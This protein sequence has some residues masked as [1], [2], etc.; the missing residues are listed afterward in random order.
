MLSLQFEAEN[1][2]EL[3]KSYHIIAPYLND[4]VNIITI[5]IFL[6]FFNHVVLP[7]LRM[8]LKLRLVI[9]LIFNLIAILIA[10]FLQA[11]VQIDSNGFAIERFLWLLLPA[12]VLSVAET[13]TFVSC[14]IL[15]LMHIHHNN[16][17][18]VK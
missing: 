8:S 18:S 17:L 10:V 7:F 1:V 4:L 9:G 14:K 11:T 5:V 15:T 12:I 16:Y 13:I 6:P 2:L 3:G